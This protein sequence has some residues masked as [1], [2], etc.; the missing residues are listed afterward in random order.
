MKTSI[1]VITLALAAAAPAAHAE[2]L[3]A[4]WK[5]PG[6]GAVMWDTVANRDWLRLDYTAGLSFNTV[7]AQLGSGGT[8]SGFAYAQ[9]ADLWALYANA[10]LTP[11]YP[12]PDAEAKAFVG[13]YGNAQWDGRDYSYHLA[14]SATPS[15]WDADWQVV[16][17]VGYGSLAQPSFA[18]AT[19]SIILATEGR[20]DVGSA[21]WRPHQDV[22][23]V[24]EP[25]AAALLLAGLAGLAWRRRR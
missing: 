11:S 20:P 1:A 7:N 14:I 22:S 4:D 9:T 24:P 19:G 5:A 13:L 25:S 23:A 12:A 6:D 8:F 15:A 21:L 18:N 17:M 3:I 10:G 16:G 2:L